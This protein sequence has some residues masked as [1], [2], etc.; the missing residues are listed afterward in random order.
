MNIETI[1]I[2]H[3]ETKEEAWIKISKDAEI[4]FKK[5]Y[6]HAPDTSLYVG[7]DYGKIDASVAKEATE[8]AGF[9]FYKIIDAADSLNISV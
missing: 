7:F 5:D 4:D 3:I 1:S 2:R 9:K 6:V 8:F